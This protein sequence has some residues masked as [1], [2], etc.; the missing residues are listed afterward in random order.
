MSRILAAQCYPCPS[1]GGVTGLPGLSWGLPSRYASCRAHK[2][3]CDG[4]SGRETHHAAALTT[5]RTLEAKGGPFLSLAQRH[6]PC[7][8]LPCPLRG[9]L[10]LEPQDHTPSG[11]L[12]LSNKSITKFS[13]ST[14]ELPPQSRSYLPFPSH[15]VPAGD[16]GLPF[17]PKSASCAQHCSISCGTAQKRKCSC[18]NTVAFSAKRLK[19]PSQEKRDIRRDE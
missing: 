4:V 10:N 12:T 14:R 9:R 2:G 18:R 5:L 8:Q 15:L 16:V 7:S 13:A 1:W 6:T 19:H 17:L 11:L 3:T